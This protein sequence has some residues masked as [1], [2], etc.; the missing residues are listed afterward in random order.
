MS[1]IHEINK[2]V[3]AHGLWKLRLRMAITAGKSEFPIE[4]IRDDTECAFGKWLNGETL[5]ASDK[6]SEEYMAAKSFHAQFHRLAGQ[7]AELAV[8][9]NKTEAERL[10]VGDFETAS[11]KLTSAMNVWRGKSQ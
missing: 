6:S 2:A 10:L 1:D 11:V 9:G 8:A 7:V 3:V 4:T 5:A